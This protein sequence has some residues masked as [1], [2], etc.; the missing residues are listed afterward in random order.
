MAAQRLQKLLARAGHG[1]RRSAEALILEG[2]VTVDGRVAVLGER[3]DIDT[4]VVAVDGRPLTLPGESTT[5]ML[6]KPPGVVVSASDERGRRTVYDLLLGAPPGLRYIGRLD[7]DSEGLL[8]LTTDG[9]LAHRLAHPRYE[10]VKTYEAT[11]EGV[12]EPAALER[13]RAG[14]ELEDGMT[15]PAAADVIER[16]DGGHALVRVAIH[17]GRK[18]EVRR[19]LAAVGH[20]VVRLVRTAFAGL[21]LGKLPAGESRPLTSEEDAAIRRLVGLA[22]AP[23]VPRMDAPQDGSL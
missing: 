3:A 12:P 1:S 18:R 2:R 16:L 5:W 21:E 13:L 14:V 23:P 17:E 11:V 19:M 9:E 22:V 15:A 20:P 7:R 10:V 8:L 6:H 4:S